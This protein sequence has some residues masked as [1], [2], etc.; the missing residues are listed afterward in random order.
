M[1]NDLIPIELQDELIFIRDTLTAQSWRIADITEEVIQFNRQKGQPF[2]LQ[3]VYAAVGLFVGKSSRT[4]REY[5]ALGRFFDPEIRETFSMLAFDHFRHA[6]MLGDRAILALQWAAEQ[7][8]W[9]NRPATVDSMIARFAPALPGEPEPPPFLDEGPAGVYSSMYRNCYPLL[10]V[11][12]TWLAYNLPD[13]IKVVV[14]RFIEAALEL[15]Q[16]L[17][18][19]ELM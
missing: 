4:V 17:P 16:A 14:N 10:K 8:D 19:T 18:K 5:H 6:A 3:S 11:S 15:M 13:E 9:L 2:E 7:T 1:Y 12:Q